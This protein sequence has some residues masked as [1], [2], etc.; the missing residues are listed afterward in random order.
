MTKQY[1][2]WVSCMN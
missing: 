2:V 1:Y